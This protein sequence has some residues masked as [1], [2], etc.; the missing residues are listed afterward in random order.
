MTTGQRNLVHISIVV[1]SLGLCLRAGT[2]IVDLWHR[3]DIM[4]VRQME[5][6]KKAEEN[7]KLKAK[8]EEIKQDEYV[9]KIARDTLGLVKDGE[10]IVI[11]PQQD[12][13]G[14]GR[15]GQKVIPNWQKW[16]N[17]FF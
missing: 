14:S 16:W 3:R 15:N 13:G 6:Q 7:I 17:L 2:T 8:L 11:L 12:S 1:L 5:L 10:A 9:E 4:R